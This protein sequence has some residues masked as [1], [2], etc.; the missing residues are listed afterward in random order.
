MIRIRIVSLAFQLDCGGASSKAHG[1][2]FDYSAVHVLTT[3]PTA[4]LAA[5]GG[6]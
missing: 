5:T 1:V 3:H 2:P 4:Q 6:K